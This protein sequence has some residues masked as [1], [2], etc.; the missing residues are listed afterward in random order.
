M[1]KQDLKRQAKENITRL[2]NSVL[3][4]IAA[5]PNDKNWDDRHVK[6]A[7]NKLVENPEL[8][9]VQVIKKIKR[10]YLCAH[11]CWFIDG[12]NYY[13][14]ITEEEEKFNKNNLRKGDKNAKDSHVKIMA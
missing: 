5:F 7:V 9:T 1:N 4:V 12:G 3:R 11:E 6:V 2:Q 14:P 8:S 13:I 10:S